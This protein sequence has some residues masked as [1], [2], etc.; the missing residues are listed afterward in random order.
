LSPISEFEYDILKLLSKS[1]TWDG[2]NHRDY[3]SQSNIF[4]KVGVCHFVERELRIEQL[5]SIVER[6]AETTSGK[7]FS[8]V[9]IFAHII[10]NHFSF[11]C[12]KE[13]KCSPFI[14]Q[15]HRRKGNEGL[16]FLI[17]VGSSAR[18]IWMFLGITSWKMSRKS[19][20]ESCLDKTANSDPPAFLWCLAS[21]FSDPPM[22]H[23]WAFGSNS[24]KE[25]QICHPQNCLNSEIILHLAFKNSFNTVNHTSQD[26]SMVFESQ[27]KSC[28][29]W[30]K[31]GNQTGS[32][33]TTI[34]VGD[35]NIRTPNR[36]NNSWLE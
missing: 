15:E 33:E 13:S 2:L 26:N 25:T 12:Q 10:E 4:D 17:G 23:R 35:A 6:S 5:F 27:R 22:R 9:L 18:K 16:E 24:V 30:C 20:C 11:V 29:K 19:V 8:L 7:C 34:E 3:S 28:Q 21:S 31:K 14:F 36:R 32:S 1:V